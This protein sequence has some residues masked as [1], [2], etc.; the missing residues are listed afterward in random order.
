MNRVSRICPALTVQLAQQ[1]AD[2]IAK[3]VLDMDGTE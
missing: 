3:W 2:V 1:A